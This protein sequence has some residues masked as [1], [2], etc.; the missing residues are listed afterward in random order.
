MYHASNKNRDDIAELNVADIGIN[1][2]ERLTYNI[3]TSPELP[4][5]VK[6]AE[7]TDIVK[8]ILTASKLD[9]AVA[10]PDER[11]IH[12]YNESSFFLDSHY[13]IHC[14]EASTTYTLPYW[15]GVY[16]GIIK[17]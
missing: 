7:I 13:Y 14:M 5:P 10:A 11:S 2:R 9:W 6:N 16:H 8:F 12:K 17:R 4:P 1:L 15:M 3:K